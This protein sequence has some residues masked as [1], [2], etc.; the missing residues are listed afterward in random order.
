MNK[1]L[2][3]DA[4][5]DNEPMKAN[6]CKSIKGSAK[7]VEESSK[8]L[9][10]YASPAKLPLPKKDALPKKRSADLISICE[11]SATRA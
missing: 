2:F 4:E 6:K 9:E 7:D 8:E 10:F 5:S 3:N 1:N 11:C